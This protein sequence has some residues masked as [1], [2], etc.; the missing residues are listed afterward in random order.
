MDDRLRERLLFSINRRD[1][2]MLL[3]A[4][5]SMGDPTRLYSAQALAQK[6]V[7]RYK[8]RTGSNRLDSVGDLEVVARYFWDEDMFEVPFISDL[9]PWE[10]RFQRRPN[11]GH[12]T[13][14]DFLLS[15]G[16]DCAISTNYDTHVEDAASDLG[17]GDFVA[18]L[19]GTEANGVPSRYRPL[20]K[21]HGCFR[22]DRNHTIWLEEQL[23][24]SPTDEQ[25]RD[26]TTWLRG[27]LQGRDLLFVGFWSDWAYLNDILSG[28]VG[29]T[30]P[31]TVVLV[32]P[33][34]SARLEAKAP[35]LWAWANGDGVWF[36]HVQEYGEV[37][38]DE[39]RREVSLAFVR[40][41]LQGSRDRY[42]ALTGNDADCEL[43]DCANVESDDLYQIRRDLTG[44][45]PSGC[46]RSLEA[47]DFE[48]P[49]AVLLGLLEQGARPEGPSFILDSP[50]RVVYAPGMRVSE[51][52]ADY[53]EDDIPADTKFIAVGAME[54]H[55]VTDI[56]RGEQQP[57]VARVTS[58]GEWTTDRAS[59]VWKG[60]E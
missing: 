15:Q 19:T 48:Y 30:A 12:R 1:L 44:C 51:L 23:A 26:A 28:A 22:V 35:D 8:A 6:V 52:V 41:A 43:P 46:V 25:I 29:T 37:F 20:L 21:L 55:A 13:V 57:S 3:G 56:I 50:Y 27:R 49:A 45:G 9:V 39:L 31:R 33:E 60:G 10:V 24:V 2:V 5:L 40:E 32:D 16:L 42:H 59:T 54:D 18:A 38:L 14:A 17:E 4:G 7:E 36:R 11:A 34:D 58:P 53:S 47:G